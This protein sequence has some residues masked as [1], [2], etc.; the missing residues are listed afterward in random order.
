MDLECSSMWEARSAPALLAPEATRIEPEVHGNIP[1][2]R[3]GEAGSTQ[4]SARPFRVRCPTEDAD[5]DENEEEPAAVVKVSLA[6]GEQARMAMATSDGEPRTSF[7]HEI[8][9][10]CVDFYYMT[11]ATCVS[12]DR[13]PASFRR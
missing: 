3:V 1:V 10:E 13:S 2:L 12:S 7:Q 11:A 4:S 9:C 8:H 6:H 5:P